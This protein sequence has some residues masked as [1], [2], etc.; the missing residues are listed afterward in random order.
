MKTGNVQLS[1]AY[2]NVNNTKKSHAGLIAAGGTLAAIAIATKTGT[3]AKLAEKSGIAGTVAKAINSVVHTVSKKASNLYSKV[4]ET[5]I[6]KK[7]TEYVSNLYKKVT[8]K[9]TGL[10]AKVKDLCSQASDK[11]TGIITKVK[12]FFAKAADKENGIIPKAKNLFVNIKEK[13]TNAFKA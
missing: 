11:K 9:E 4:K 10:G 7:A 1:P 12:D 8:N 13:I 6:F 2:T 3:T 5:G